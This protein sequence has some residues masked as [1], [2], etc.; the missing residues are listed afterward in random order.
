MPKF[1][2]SVPH[3]EEPAEV[4]VR[5]RQ[6]SEQ[7]R[8]TSRI[9]VTEVVEKWDDQGNLEFSFKAMGFTV[10]GRVE[11]RVTEVAVFGVIPFAALP[12]RGMIE[13][14]VAAKIREALV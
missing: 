11:T 3:S 13:Q 9:Q 12:L 2:V 7:V 1:N 6:F 5:L 10:S 8:R 4:A 14:E